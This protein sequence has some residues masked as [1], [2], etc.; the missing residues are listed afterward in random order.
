MLSNVRQ[1]LSDQVRFPRLAANRAG[2]YESTTTLGVSTMMKKTMAMA[3]AAAVLVG[4]SGPAWAGNDG[5]NRRVTI[6]NISSQTIYNLYASPVAATT[7]EEDLLGDSTIPAGQSL[8]ANIDNGTNECN[9]DL[10]VVMAN[11]REYIRRRVNVCAVSKWTIGDSG[12]SI[13]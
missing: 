5:K 3:A 1:I 12:N 11:G 9:Y 2:A 8:V 10:K 6:E 13:Q 4:T 7:W